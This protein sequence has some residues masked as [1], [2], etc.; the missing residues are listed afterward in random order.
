MPLET[1]TSIAQ[2][3]AFWPLSSDPVNQ[4]EDHLQLIKSVLKAQFPGEA[5]EGFAIPITATEAEINFLEGAQSNIQQQID[6]IITGVSGAL[7]APAGTIMVFGTYPSPPG[8]TRLTNVND[9]MLRLVSGNPGGTGGTMSPTSMS[10]QHS[11][12]TGGHALSIDEIPSHGHTVF[13]NADSNVDITSNDYAAA[14]YD[15]GTTGANSYRMKG[16]T[17]PTPSMGKTS[18][19][20]SGNQHTHGPTGTLIASLTPIYFNVNTAVKS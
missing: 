14:N 8:W 11:H 12:T 5:G 18:L 1:G 10:I 15:A 20:G 9:A 3:N 19:V 7:D 4:G 13:A 6:D 2:L 17:T 16:V